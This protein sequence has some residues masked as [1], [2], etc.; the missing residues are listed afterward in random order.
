MSASIKETTSIKLDKQA[1]DSAKLIFKALG[2]TMGD[3]V[4]LFLHQVNLQQGIPFDIKLPNATT[5]QVIDDARHGV[6]ID[7]FSLD[8]LKS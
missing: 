2:M 7:D 8:D 5:Q 3:A 6:N 4:N 1:K